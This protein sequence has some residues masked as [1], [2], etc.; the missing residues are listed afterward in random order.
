M[1]VRMRVWRIISDFIMKLDLK[2]E[3][4]STSELYILNLKLLLYCIVYVRICKR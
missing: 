2:D 4:V 3:S 1:Y